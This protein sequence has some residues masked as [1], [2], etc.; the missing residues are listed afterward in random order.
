MKPASVVGESE[1]L[2]K[3]LGS[4]T[5]L[6]A[7]AGVAKS[8]KP[9]L[10]K[11]DVIDGSHFAFRLFLLVMGCHGGFLYLGFSIFGSKRDISKLKIPIRATTGRRLKCG[12]FCR[13]RNRARSYPNIIAGRNG[14]ARFGFP[15]HVDVHSIK[16]TYPHCMHYQLLR[17]LTSCE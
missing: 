17:C 9:L 15:G 13:S 14:L 7:S 16:S 4:K 11:P 5:N 2:R 6:R 1:S 3:I 10:R 12:C 8:A